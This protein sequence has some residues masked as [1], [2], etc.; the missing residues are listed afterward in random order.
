[1][2]KKILHRTFLPFKRRPIYVKCFTSQHKMSNPLDIRKTNDLSFASTETKFKNP[3]TK[4]ILLFLDF[5]IKK[6]YYH[7]GFFWNNLTKKPVFTKKLFWV[8]VIGFLNLVSVDAKERSLIT[9]SENC[10]F[11]YQWRTV[12][13]KI[14]RKKTKVV[15]SYLLKIQK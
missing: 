13:I 4:T 2:R 15:T 1:M 5:F 3:I 9:K 7:L 11:F 14:F 10:W 8:L 6:W 12:F